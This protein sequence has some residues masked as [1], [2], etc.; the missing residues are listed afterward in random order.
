M[1][2]SKEFLIA[3]KTVKQLTK[4]PSNEE[5][6]VLYGLYKQSTVGD[7]NVEKPGFL[8]FREVKKWE[9][10]DSYKGLSQFDAEVKYIS[11]VNELIQKY[12]IIYTTQDLHP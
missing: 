6:Q 8:N 10:W 9:S 7:I 3:A 12:G 5:L 2:N 4:S 1:P 11:W